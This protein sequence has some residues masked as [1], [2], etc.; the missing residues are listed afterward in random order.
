MRTPLFASSLGHVAVPTGHVGR[1]VWPKLTAPAPVRRHAHHLSLA[2]DVLI[3]VALVLFTVLAL[4]A[5]AV[6]QPWL[7]ARDADAHIA[8]SVDAMDGAMVNM[9]DVIRTATPAEV[10]A[11][12]ARFDTGMRNAVSE[13]AAAESAVAGVRTGP[14]VEEYTAAIEGLQEAMLNARDV[15]DRIAVLPTLTTSVDRVFSAEHNAGLNLA[16]A[17]AALKDGDWGRAKWL[18]ALAESDFARATRLMAPVVRLGAMVDL[19][20][21]HR[22]VRQISLERKASEEL[23]R[24]AELSSRGQTA[25][26]AA[27]VDRLEAVRAEIHKRDS[28]V[29]LDTQGAIERTQAEYDAARL[30]LL[31]AE[32][33]WEAASAVMGAR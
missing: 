14:A 7:A 27:A 3:V 2:T 13:L 8:S 25:A 12:A 9:G 4:Q 20:T 30:Q 15:R 29:W 16:A 31:E 6:G 18:S 32:K 21:A 33:R 28:F 10:S 22:F 17:D 11:R 26:A 5:W 24:A 23:H 19:T 1:G